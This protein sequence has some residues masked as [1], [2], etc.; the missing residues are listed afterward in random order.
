MPAVAIHNLRPMGGN[1]QASLKQNKID[2]RVRLLSWM[3]DGVEAKQKAALPAS[4]SK[5]SPHHRAVK[6]SLHNV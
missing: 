3:Q 5:F 4:S 6:Y 1:S 2:P